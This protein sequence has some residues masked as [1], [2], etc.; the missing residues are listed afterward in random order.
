MGSGKSSVGKRLAS[1][2]NYGF[3]DLDAQIEMKE[4]MTISKVFSEKGE[5][6]FR[7]R[8]IQV[9]NDLI[10]SDKQSIIATGGG[11]PCYGNVMNFLTSEEKVITIYLKTSLDI[12]SE[13]LFIEKDKRPLISH[14]QDEISMK[15]FIRKHLFERSFYYN[16]SSLAIDTNTKSVDEIV[17]EIVVNLF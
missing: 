2:L 12:L 3:I 8:E 13:R 5:I 1:T 7:K 17:K 16:Q 6:Y 11:T 4:S 15:D 9:L 10:L 14:I